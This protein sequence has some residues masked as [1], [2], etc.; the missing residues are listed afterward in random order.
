MSPRTINL[1]GVEL[2]LPEDAP[3]HIT[4]EEMRILNGSAARYVL[5][6]FGAGMPKYKV[7]E[8]LEEVQRQI[9]ERAAAKRARRM[10]RNASLPQA[11]LRSV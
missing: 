2:E 11:N 5:P 4:P 1:H 8:T 7:H 10:K 3:E 6:W 9:Q